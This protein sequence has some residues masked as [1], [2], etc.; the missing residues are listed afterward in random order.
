[1]SWQATC[2]CGVLVD[3][4]TERPGVLRAVEHDSA[5]RS[6]GR[7]A[8]WRDSG[9]LRC[10]MLAEDEQLRPGERRGVLHGSRHTAAPGRKGKSNG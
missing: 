8:L 2:S 6:E 3:W 10:R 1:V 9:V 4:A 5:G 7:L